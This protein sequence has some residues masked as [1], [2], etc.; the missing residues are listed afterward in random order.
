[1]I[2]ARFY[3]FLGSDLKDDFYTAVN[4]NLL[5]TLEIPKDQ[6][7]A[8]GSATVSANTDKQ[9]KDLIMEIVNSGVEYPQGSPQQKIRDFYQSYEE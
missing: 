9:L 1:M 4:Q 5:N 6:E 2:A 7:S 8:G 3:T